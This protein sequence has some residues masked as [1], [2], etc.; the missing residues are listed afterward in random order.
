MSEG[1]FRNGN[2]AETYCASFDQAVLGTESRSRAC[3]GRVGW[4]CSSVAGPIAVEHWTGLSTAAAGERKLVLKWK[5]PDEIRPISESPP[6]PAVLL[7]SSSRAVN[8][9][10]EGEAL[11]ATGN[12]TGLKFKFK[13]PVAT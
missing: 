8:I 3:D 10:E 7:N 6:A 2:Q 1:H 13:L 12:R 5:R 4:R 9:D 11:A